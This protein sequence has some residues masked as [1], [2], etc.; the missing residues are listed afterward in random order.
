MGDLRTERME[1]LANDLGAL[2]NEV[3]DE[4]MYASTLALGGVEAHLRAAEDKVQEAR[5]ALEK[6]LVKR[7]LQAPPIARDEA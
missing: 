2:H 5:M 1:A 7:R 6:V 4:R 3:Q